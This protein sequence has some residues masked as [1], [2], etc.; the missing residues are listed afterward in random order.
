M[1]CHVLILQIFGAPK[2]LCFQQNG[3][4]VFNQLNSASE[5][6]CTKAMCRGH[7][8]KSRAGVT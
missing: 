2:K 4:E 7:G 6:S 8:V 1:I 5:L 3:E